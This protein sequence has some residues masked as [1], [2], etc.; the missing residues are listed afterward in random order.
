MPASAL[1]WTA[2]IVRAA[3]LGCVL[4]V[5]AAFAVVIGTHGEGIRAVA[6][7]WLSDLVGGELSYDTIAVTRSGRVEIRNL[8]LR[9]WPNQGSSFHA[10]RLVVRPDWRELVAGSLRFRTV[11][12][13]GW[14]L[15]L[16]GGDRTREGEPKAGKVPKVELVEVLCHDGDVRLVTPRR[17]FNLRGVDLEGLVRLGDAES[18]LRMRSARASVGQGFDVE[19]EGSMWRLGTGP[20]DARLLVRSDAGT[21]TGTASQTDAGW[22]W[23]IVAEGVRLSAWAAFFDVPPDSVG[24]IASF[25]ARGQGPEGR[26]H[27][28]VRSPRWGRWHADVLEGTLHAGPTSLTLSDFH[29]GDT[30]GGLGGSLGLAREA[31]GWAVTASLRGDSVSVPLRGVM[32]TVSGSMTVRGRFSPNA[33]DLTATFRDGGLTWHDWRLE[34]I[35]GKVRWRGEG[36]FVDHVRVA[37][38]HLQGEARGVIS[39][40]RVELEHDVAVTPSEG[41]QA[42]WGV[43]GGARVRGKVSGAPSRLAWRGRVEAEQVQARGVRVQDGSFLGETILEGRA[44][45][46]RGTLGAT[47]VQVAG[48]PRVRAARIELEATNH[49]IRVE[50]GLLMRPDGV[51]TSWSGRWGRGG[52]ELTSVIILSPTWGAATLGTTRIAFEQGRIVIPQLRLATTGGGFVHARD[53]L[54]ARGVPRGVVLVQHLPAELVAGL[55]GLPGRFSGRCYGVFQGGDTLNGWASI[56]ALRRM[57][58]M[59]DFPADIECVFSKDS[60]RTEV[61]SLSV[62][63]GDLR[64]TL[65]GSLDSGGVLS[66]EAETDRGPLHRV[67]VIA[68]ELL[69]AG[70]RPIFDARAGTISA[71]VTAA[72]T[73]QHPSLEGSIE[74]DGGAEIAVK[75]IRTTFRSVK[76]RGRLVG[77]SVIVEEATG[78]SGRGRATLQGRV[79]LPSLVLDAA[80]F[81]V[82]GRRLEFRAV[83]GIWGIYDADLR[84]A[85]RGKGIALE[86]RAQISEALL[87]LPSLPVEPLPPTPAS[88]DDQWFLTLTAQR[89][90]WVRDR[91]LNA[92][93]AGEVALTK[94]H[95]VIGLQGDLEVLRG[96]YLY[97]GRK[98][99]LQGGRVSF[100]GGPLIVPE[101]DVTATTVIRSEQR[102]GGD[103]TL[104]LTV[105]GRVDNPVLR[106][107]AGDEAYTEEQ[108]K[109]MLLFNLSPEDVTSLWQGDA[110]AKE[111]AG[112]VE[113]F[114]A[115]EL[116]RVLRAETGLDELEVSPNLLA[117]EDPDLYVR[118]GKYLTPE[119]FV[120]VAKG[121]RT[122]GLDEVRVEYVLRSLASRL[123][124]RSNVDLKLVGER[125]QD[126][127]SRTNYHVQMKLRYRF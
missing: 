102:D 122:M 57:P 70:L 124:L 77:H 22:T 68:D 104:T 48:K 3:L 55:V 82:T 58:S 101:L 123:G 95:G 127:Y 108:I 34:G 72:G 12:I 62:T 25:E 76:G 67:L 49:T 10:R 6:L 96:T 84:L 63:Q 60:S 26:A 99:V 5:L 16:R 53:L 110:F 92:E 121:L 50:R 40:T 91:F 90:V 51:V 120:S 45:L 118:L 117:S 89:S 52:G 88:L 46:A 113:E 7:G 37:S 4:F 32:A 36:F 33:P 24:G 94:E 109:T 98:F 14:L 47:E 42:A 111:A 80:S 116:V 83:R 115:G 44:W 73:L 38:G 20:W 85:K 71:K 29:V 103:I 19:A 100:M 81:S 54:V 112:A 61:H 18:S 28:S 8:T 69:A 66:A 78:T 56:K 79:E 39:S 86:G 27:V 125:S 106:V 119:L 17:T 23:G 64:I 31:D 1:R 65:R 30:R 13:E 75:P 87:D 41:F 93:V 74:V 107:S 11:R 97:L 126:E 43:R 21:L 114:V 9:G 15:V 105:T 35:E 2:R 59:A